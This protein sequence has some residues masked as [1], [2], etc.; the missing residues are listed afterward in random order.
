MNIITIH[1]Y[2]FQCP[3]G[4]AVSPMCCKLDGLSRHTY[5]KPHNV[6]A[7][8]TMRSQTPIKLRIFQFLYPPA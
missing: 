3:R 8:Q 7:R 2:T 1:L 5:N 4:L 6:Y